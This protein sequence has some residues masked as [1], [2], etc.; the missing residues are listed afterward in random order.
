MTY[1]DV[2]VLCLQLVSAVTKMTKT[3]P[4]PKTVNTG[5]QL[6]KLSHLQVYSALEKP[7]KNTF[8]RLNS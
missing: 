3:K 2:S 4:K 5:C 7:N 8:C 1:D 6:V